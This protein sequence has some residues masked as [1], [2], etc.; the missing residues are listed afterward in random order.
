LQGRLPWR[1]SHEFV[2]RK[3]V[4]DSGRFSGTLDDFDL[5]DD[6]LGVAVVVGSSK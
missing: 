1:A 5:V 4:S 2:A 6:A 3:I